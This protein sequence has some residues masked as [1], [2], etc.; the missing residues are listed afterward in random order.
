[1]RATTRNPVNG[2]YQYTN[3]DNDCLLKWEHL[4][5]F[6]VDIFH[7]HNNFEV[8]FKTRRSQSVF[9]VWFLYVGLLQSKQFKKSNNSLKN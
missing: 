4:H 9:H 7:K 6:N 8:I 1:M 5:L 3:D 2:F